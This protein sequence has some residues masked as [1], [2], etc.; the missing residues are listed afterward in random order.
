[1]ASSTMRFVSFRMC[2][3]RRIITKMNQVKLA[4]KTLIVATLTHVIGH[5]ISKN[6]Y[7]AAIQ[8]KS[9]KKS[10]LISSSFPFGILAR[11]RMN[12]PGCI[13]FGQMALVQ[14]LKLVK[15]QKS[16]IWLTLSFL[17]INVLTLYFQNSSKFKYRRYVP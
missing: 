2:H 16:A 14:T 1:M 6:T 8:P 15:V 13:F 3:Q 17:L 7:K 9:F 10:F 12:C 11:A 4:T 5:M